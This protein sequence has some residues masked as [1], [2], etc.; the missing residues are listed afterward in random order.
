MS[1]KNQLHVQFVTIGKS[2]HVGAIGARIED[3]RGPACRI[4]D[5][6]G[7]HSHIVITRVELRET[8]SLLDSL[9]AP[10]VLRQL[11]KRARGKVQ[12]W[13]D[14][15]QRRFIK[16]AFAHFAD[17][18]QVDA[19]LFCQF[20]IGNSQTALRFSDDIANVVF[21]RDRG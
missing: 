20:G 12:D 16:V 19:C 4:P 10:L 18:L 8:V 3:R 9:R 21:K 17:C 2:Q 15:Q 1:K 11:A 14:A 7:V 6:I 5:E 13:C